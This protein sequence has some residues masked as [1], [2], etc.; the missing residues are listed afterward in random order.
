V[1]G[2]AEGAITRQAETPDGPPSASVT[3]LATA[4]GILDYSW[5][6]DGD[7]GLRLDFFGLTD[8]PGDSVLIVPELSTGALLGLGVLAIAIGQR[9]IRRV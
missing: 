7:L 6:T 5:Q 2:D 3:L 9:W 8:A 4:P 1:S